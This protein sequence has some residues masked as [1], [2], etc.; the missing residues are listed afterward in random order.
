M[1]LGESDF[2]IYGNDKSYLNIAVVE[3]K[4]IERFIDGYKQLLGYLNPSFMFGITISINKNKQLGVA[5]DYIKRKLDA[6]HDDFKLVN[7]V[8]NPLGDKFKYIIKS[9]HVLPEDGSRTMSVY[10]LIINLYD[11]G[12][13]R[14]AIES[15]KSR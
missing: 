3:S 7:I 2:V 15:R 6:N 4:L 1:D 13:K 8:E 14:I 9:E 5:S 10:H 12:R 11:L